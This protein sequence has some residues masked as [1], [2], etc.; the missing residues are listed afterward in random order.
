MLCTQ[1]SLLLHRLEEAVYDRPFGAAAL[2]VGRGAFVADLA[3]E[4]L[5][6]VTM[7][8]L[9]NG[10]SFFRRVPIRSS[11]SPDTPASAVLPSMREDCR[12]RRAAGSGRVN[13][14][15]RA[16]QPCSEDATFRI[17]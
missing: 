3:L 15:R 4:P 5:V 13:R 12:K 7:M 16:G 9:R 6:W 2:Q 17:T 8:L 10:D 1:R 14:C 11:T